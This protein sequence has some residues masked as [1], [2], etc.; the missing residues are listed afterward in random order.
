MAYDVV[1]LRPKD[2]FLRAGVTPPHAFAIAYCTPDDPELD[3]L[4]KTTR[5]L[6]IPAVG[7]KLT[8]TLFETS[9]VQLVQVT[10][11][12]FDRLDESAMKKLGIPVANVPGA[13][14]QALVEYVVTSA[15]VLLRRFAWADR[16]LKDDRYIPF[17]QAMVEANLGGLEGITIGIIGL[18]QIGLTVARAFHVMGSKIVFCDSA[19]PDLEGVKKIGAQSLALDEVLARSDVVTVH[20]PLVPATKNLIGERELAAMKPGAI[21]IHAARGGVVDESAL[22]AHLQSGHLGGAAVDVYAQE[23]PTAD[24]PLFSIEG[25]AANRLLLTPHIAGVS[26]QSWAKLFREA[27]EN[28]ERVLLKGE[29]PRNRVL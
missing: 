27:W 23:P 20:V 4:I 26:K 8:P 6:V 3:S 1:C 9:Q 18:G 28:V 10:G 2:D 16:E 5:A 21:L 14:N 19:P 29:P 17:R 12:G 15:L 22:A 7:P 13:T 11:A 25:E 24:N